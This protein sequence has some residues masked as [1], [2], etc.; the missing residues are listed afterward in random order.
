MPKISA[1]T[2][3]EHRA[4]TVD[5]IFDAVARLSRDRGIDTISMTQVAAEAGVTRTAMYNYFP[6][7]AALLLAFTE[8][9]TAY[10]VESFEQGL[11]KN[12]DATTRLRAFI[13]LQLRGLVAHPHPNAAEV[14]A[15]LGPEAYEAL[16]AHVAPMQRILT[17]ILAEGMESGEFRRADV[18]ATARSVLA[19]VGAE[20]L[21]LISDATTI[22]KSER[23]VTA[24]V[25][26]G[27]AAP[28]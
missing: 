23:N 7:K 20:R 6:D 10:F 4:Q 8:R 28:E 26:G 1:T 13:R 11:P 17:G 22:R 19:T 16:A 18:E 21:P 3:G 25:L 27:V 15:A 14:T 24:F 5:R 9:V 12:A 2:L